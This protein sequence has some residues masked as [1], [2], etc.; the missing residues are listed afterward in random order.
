[1]FIRGA[2]LRVPRLAPW[3]R[4]HLLSPPQR[5]WGLA[6]SSP[7]GADE[8]ELPY[9]AQ[10]AVSGRSKCKACKQSIEKG[11]LRI[12]TRVVIHDHSSLQWKCWPCWK[13]PRNLQ[14]LEDIE[15]FQALEQADRDGIRQRVSQRDASQKVTSR[16]RAGIGA[17]SNEELVQSKTPAEGRRAERAPVPSLLVGP[18]TTDMCSEASAAMRVQRCDGS[19]AVGSTRR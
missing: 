19:E 14:T 10:Y 9:A 11:K 7:G 3:R 13:V 5:R 17:P 15:G 8:D 2:G 6:M 1:M 12:G 4:P 18:T 16:K